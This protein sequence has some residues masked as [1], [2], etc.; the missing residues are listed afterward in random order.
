MG[1]DCYTVY[2]V[3]VRRGLWADPAVQLVKGTYK[4][5]IGVLVR[6]NGRI[7]THSLA[8][9]VGGVAWHWG[10]FS[11]CGTDA[12][13]ICAL[14]TAP[15]TVALTVPQAASRR[16]RARDECRRLSVSTWHQMGIEQCAFRDQLWDVTSKCKQS[17]MDHFE[18]I[19]YISDFV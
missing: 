5:K 14:T 15:A 11:R 10:L 8:K 6:C 9:R 16:P 17:R 2:N 1:A 18:G 7:T 13:N 19:H 12:D 4:I 3:W